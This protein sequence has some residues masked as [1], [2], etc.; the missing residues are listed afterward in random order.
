M[1][2]KL[3]TVIVTLAIATGVM[4]STAAPA[5]ASQCGGKPIAS[6]RQMHQH[7]RDS[8]AQPDRQAPSQGQESVADGY[9]PGA[10]AEGEDPDDHGA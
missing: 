4:V 3:G 6:L 5:V 7:P 2:A 9:Y 10:G 1:K 8:T